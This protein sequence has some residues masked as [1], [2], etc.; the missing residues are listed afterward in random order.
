MTDSKGFVGTEEGQ[1]IN[2]LEKNKGSLGSLGIMPPEVYQQRH[3]LIGVQMV[4]GLV[5][6]L[7]CF[8][9]GTPLTR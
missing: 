3:F 6:N 7:G 2:S 8:S 4:K 9:P 1:L 5:A